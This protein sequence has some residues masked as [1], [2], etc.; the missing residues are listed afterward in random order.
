MNRSNA[1]WDLVED[2][3]RRLADFG[4]LKA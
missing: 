2:D 3:Y 1:H 4:I